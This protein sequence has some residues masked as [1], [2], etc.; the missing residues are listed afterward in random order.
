M[1]VS[2]RTSIV[3]VSTPDMSHISATE[4]HCP[5]NTEHYIFITMSMGTI[6][7]E[8]VPNAASCQ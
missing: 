1:D 3:F 7:I 2:I 6:F 5:N 8:S 4:L